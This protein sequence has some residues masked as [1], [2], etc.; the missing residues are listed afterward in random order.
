MLRL[1]PPSPPPSPATSHPFLLFFLASPHLPGLPRSNSPRLAL[2]QPPGTRNRIRFDCGASSNHCFNTEVNH[3]FFHR[4][5]ETEQGVTTLMTPDR[6]R[7]YT[8]AIISALALSLPLP[9]LSFLSFARSPSPASL[10]SSP[11]D[12][13][14]TRQQELASGVEAAAVVTDAALHLL[15]LEVWNIFFNFSMIT[16]TEILEHTS[17]CIEFFYLNFHPVV[18][19]GN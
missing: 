5:K 15:L 12:Q 16:P 19:N 13:V 3:E 2:A 8:G 6:F 18:I 14:T 4:A 11:S 17:F 9:H 1:T 7:L 10:A